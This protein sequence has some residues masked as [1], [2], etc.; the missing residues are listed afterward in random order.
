MVF[1]VIVRV[2]SP[3]SPV[4]L[5]ALLKIFTNICRTRRLSPITSSCLIF[6][7]LTVKFCFF[8][9]TDGLMISS[10]SSRRSERLNSDSERLNFPDSILLI[11]STSLIRDSRC[12]PA[13]VIFARQSLILS[14]SS[15]CVS[16]IAVSPIIAFIG[17]R[18][19]WDIRE[20]KS[21]L[22]LLALSAS[23]NACSSALRFSI[24]SFFRLVTSSTAASTLLVS[25]PSMFSLIREYFSHLP[26]SAS[27]YSY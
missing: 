27:S 1:S 4:Y 8:S 25:S 26:F 20:R 24:S 21:I 18:I 9:F 16:A 2:M 6:S 17:V 15:I 22:A 13:V 23:R 7:A 14:L 10:T 12:L 19:S 5:T 11:S 3:P